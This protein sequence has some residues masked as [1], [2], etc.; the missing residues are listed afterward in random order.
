VFPEVTPATRIVGVGSVFGVVLGLC[1]VKLVGALGGVLSTVIW[2]L[3][4]T[5]RDAFPASS[6]TAPAGTAIPTVPL[7]VQELKEIVR[8]LPVPATP[9]LEQSAVPVFTRLTSPPVKDTVYPLASVKVAM[10]E[11]VPALFIGDT[12]GALIETT[13]RVGSYR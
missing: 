4:V 12:L 6:I 1:L 13:G 8:V 11:L 10:N 5:E 9:M 3:E 2:A 7:P